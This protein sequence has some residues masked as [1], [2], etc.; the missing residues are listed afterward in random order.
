MIFVISETFVDLRFREVGKI[1]QRILDL[2]S[3]DEQADY[4]MRADP[5]ALDSDLAIANVRQIHQITIRSCF[6]DLKLSL[7]RALTQAARDGRN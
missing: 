2:C 1:A 4:I 5:R 3:V 7:N 6:H